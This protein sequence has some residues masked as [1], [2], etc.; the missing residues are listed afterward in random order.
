MKRLIFILGLTV[1]LVSCQKE[2]ISK[3]VYEGQYVSNEISVTRDKNTKA[4]IL[5]VNTNKKWELYA[6]YSTDSIDF[7]RPLMKG[8]E[9]G[10]Y[11]L[12]ISNTK[13]S[14]FQLVTD[15][16]KAILSE[17]HLPM[18]G[19]YNFRDLGG[20]LTADGRYVKWG[21]IFR[22]DDLNK[23]TDDDLTYLSNI[24]ITS[25]VDFRT[26]REIETAP[27]KTPA[28]LKNEYTYNITPGK[29]SQEDISKATKEELV[30]EMKLMNRLLVSDSACVAQYKKFFSLLQDEKEVPLMFHC[31][32]GKDRTGMGAALIL[33]ALGVN[34]ATIKEDYLASNVY[35]A[36]KYTPLIEEHPNMQPLFEVKAEYLEAGIDQMKKDHGSVENYLT[37]VLGVDIPKFRAMYLY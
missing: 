25:I 16:G 22:S 6:G 7:T 35:L 33:F 32:A 1:L 18:A 20:I 24:P 29:L 4:A 2:K 9:G 21:K 14:Y 12:E 30:E 34:E 11:P 3:A 28:S 8:T 17:R 15:E 19:G 31:S 23:L 27:D 5:N 26:E 36:G 37:N 13:R 10:L